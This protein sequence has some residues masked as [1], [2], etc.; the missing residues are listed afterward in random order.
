MFA[1]A[2]VRIVSRQ[3]VAAATR[4]QFSALAAKTVTRQSA[5]NAAPLV[6]AAGLAMPA[7]LFQQREVCETIIHVF[8]AP[9]F[10]KH[11]FVVCIYLTLTILLYLFNNIYQKMTKIRRKK[12]TICLEARMQ[13]RKSNKSLEPTGLAT[14]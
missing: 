7:A 5:R 13:S 10:I 12:P 3:T 1:S 9:F 2:A 11:Q 6:A 14:F 4:R 8:C